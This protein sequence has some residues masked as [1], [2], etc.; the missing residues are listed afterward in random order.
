MVTRWTTVRQT[1][2]SR[3]RSTSI[4]RQLHRSDRHT[5]LEITT[6][7][8]CPQGCRRCPGMHGRLSGR[9][10][11]PAW[12]PHC[13]GWL[14]RL[15]L[16]RQSPRDPRA[17]GRPRNYPGR[18]AAAPG[19]PGDLRDAL[20]RRGPCRHRGD[21]HRFHLPEPD[22]QAV[23]ARP[24]GRYYLDVD[25]LRSGWEPKYTAPNIWRFRHGMPTSTDTTTSPPAG[26]GSCSS[27]RARCATARTTSAPSSPERCGKRAGT[28]DQ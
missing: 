12:M 25:W 13:A 24:G 3:R 28:S 7:T 18:S 11:G 6:G 5:C 10:S 1:P 15:R 17:A 2:R 8:R 23:V 20:S 27:R 14:R 19:R 21:L 16:T 4:L 22:R 9:E 26:G